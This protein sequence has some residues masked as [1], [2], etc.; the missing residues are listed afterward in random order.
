[1]DIFFHD[2]SDAP[3][4]PEEV[5]IR[6][7]TAS[8]YPDGR[9]VKIYLEVTPFLKRPSG[10]ILLKNQE[11]QV[12]AS[13]N[14]IETMTHKMELTLHIRGGAD[15]GDYQVCADLFYQEVPKEDPNGGTEGQY[16]LSERKQVDYTEISFSIPA[17]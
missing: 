6:E 16:E 2:P 13:A 15:A 12:L 3:V 17:Q 4:P 14:I 10:E 7:F 8:P 11:G 9:R 1:M 5:R